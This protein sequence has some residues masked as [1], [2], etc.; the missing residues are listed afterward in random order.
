MKFKKLNIDDRMRNFAKLW[1]KDNDLK[2][3]T[4]EYAKIINEDQ[5]KL[6][7]IAQKY[8]Q[9]HKDKQNLKKRLKGKKVTD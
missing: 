4:N 7:Q 8:S 2:I 9:A 5:N 6:F 1:A 3:I